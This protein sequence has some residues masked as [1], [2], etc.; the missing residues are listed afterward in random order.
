M[1][2]EIFDTTLRDGSQGAGISFSVEDKLKIAR[3]LAG[4][5]IH[6]IEGGW[7]GSNPKDEEFFRRA[8]CDKKIF[9]RLVAF[10][11]TGHRDVLAHRDKNLL[12]IVHSRARIACIFGKAW[13]LHVKYALKTTNEHNLR[14]VYD[15]IKFLRSRGLKVIF[16]AEHF[17]DGYLSNSEYARAVLTKAVAA[18]AFNLTLAETNGG[19]TPSVVARIVREVKKSFPKQYLG[20]HTHNDSDC[21]VANTLVAVRPAVAWFR[22]QLMAMEKDVEMPI[23]VR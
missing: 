14:L 23:S 7:P 1:K 16:D 8:V 12:A 6:Y 5:G 4:F 9:P 11:S 21:A 19:A 15:S 13:D 2:V 18:G 20:I 3:A 17:F 10:G 22:A